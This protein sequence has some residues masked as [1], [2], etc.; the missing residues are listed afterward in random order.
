MEH[1]A[2][3]RVVGTCRE[4]QGVLL[5]FGLNTGNL[6]K[7]Y[8]NDTQLSRLGWWWWWLWRHHLSSQAGPIQFGA[9]LYIKWVVNRLTE[10]HRKL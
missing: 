8:L 2:I 10:I 9:T 4:C 7:Y 5:S 6:L 1:Q 3:R